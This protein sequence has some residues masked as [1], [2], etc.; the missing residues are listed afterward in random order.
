VTE[1]RGDPHAGGRRVAVVVARF[2]EIV[3]RRLLAGAL[4]GLRARGVANEDVDVAWVPGAFE[5]PAQPVDVRRPAGPVGPLDDDQ[6]A[7]EVFERHPGDPVAVPLE[8]RRGASPAADVAP[9]PGSPRADGAAGTP[10]GASRP[11]P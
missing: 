4:D 10:P 8:S 7:G 9:M 5:L 11:S 6:P 2:N 3:T 1:F